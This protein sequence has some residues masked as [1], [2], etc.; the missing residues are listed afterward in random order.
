MD[1]T[2]D[3]SISFTMGFELVLASVPACRR[4]GPDGIGETP[5]ETLG[6]A[7]GLGLE[8]PGQTMAD[9]IG[10]TDA[11]EGVP[12]GWRMDRGP[13]GT[14]EAVCELGAIICE[15]GMDGMTE[16]LQKA[17]EAG[18]DGG[19]VP[20]G[21]DLDM[22]EACRALN[23]HEDVS[24]GAA[25]AR[26]MLQIGMD[27]PE[28]VRVEAA[29]LDDGW[30]LRLA[31]A[32]PDKAAVDRTARQLWVHAAFHHFHD[33]VQWQFEFSPQL[34]NDVFLGGRQADGEALWCVGTIRGRGS[35]LPAPDRR[36]IDAEF[37]G[38]LG[39]AGGAGLI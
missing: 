24:F 34:A 13:I 7:V 6:H 16:S 11:I 22:D 23:G 18:C 9:A 26:E 5:V 31:D 21:D 19:G 38:K 35:A 20:P 33:V 29:R 32:V 14:A 37:S 12:A 17:L 27:E 4:Q 36:F 3:E 8:G 39:N 15:H 1:E 10:L 25:K 28:W 2:V 30:R